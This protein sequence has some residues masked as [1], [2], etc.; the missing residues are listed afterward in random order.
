MP[1]K[2][3]KSIP[4]AAAFFAAA[5]LQAAYA[6]SA[7][8][9]LA[10]YWLGAGTI[11]MK[12]GTSERI[13]C[14]GSYAISP[15]GNALNQ[16]LLCAS[17]SYKFNVKS[18][19]FETAPGVLTGSWAETTR[20]ANGQLSGRVAGPRIFASVAGVG[21]TAAIAILTRGRMQ[22]VT[23]TPTGGTDV[24]RVAVSMHKE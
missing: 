20:N 10:G 16:S 8:R 11:S 13:R 3:S 4:L 22:S 21:F 18:D 12:N 24:V 1:V 9:P 2:L 15:A 14:R 23:I 17:D 7:L 5:S 19:V 6:E